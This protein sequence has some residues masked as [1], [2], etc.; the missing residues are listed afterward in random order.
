MLQAVHRILK[1]SE[2]VRKSKMLDILS[3]KSLPKNEK[4]IM[5]KQT[6]IFHKSFRWTKSRVDDHHH[7]HQSR[8]DDQDDLNVHTDVDGA[9]EPIKYLSVEWLQTR[10]RG[11]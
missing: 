1:F 2:K 6:N 3:W 5:Y 4:P 8:V 11:R 7:H 9:I 10:P